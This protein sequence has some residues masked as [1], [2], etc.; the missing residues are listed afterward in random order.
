MGKLRMNYPD[1]SI[2][3]VNWNTKKLLHDCIL[4]IYENTGG[5]N[6]EIIVVDNGSSDGSGE[7]VDRE[8]AGVK[9]IANTENHGFASANNQAIAVAKS[10]YLLLLN[11]DTLILP[12]AI[13]NVVAFADSHKKAAVVGCRVLN[14]DRTLQRP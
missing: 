1:V 4:S 6:F 13:E 3:I 14:P 11:S 12:C 9:L 8:F 7:M 2:I 10:K 5:L